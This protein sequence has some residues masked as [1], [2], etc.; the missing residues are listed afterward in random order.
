MTL[1]VHF[2]HEE[3]E[4]G[5]ERFSNMPSVPQQMKRAELRVEILIYL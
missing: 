3:T 1:I 4:G 5:P 2:L